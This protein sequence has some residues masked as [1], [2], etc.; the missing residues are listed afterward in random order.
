MRVLGVVT[1]CPVHAPGALPLKWDTLPTTIL[2]PTW[3]GG[4]IFKRRPSPSFASNGAGLRGGGRPFLNLCRILLPPPPRRFRVEGGRREKLEI[5]IPCQIKWS[6]WLQG[7]GRERRSKRLRKGRKRNGMT[8]AVA[9]PFDAG[10]GRPFIR[11]D[12]FSRWC[13]MTF[14]E[15]KGLSLVVHFGILGGLLEMFVSLA[16]RCM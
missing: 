9:H 3:R 16:H 11:H 6:G 13:S 2:F 7:R 10:G 1:E 15:G 5:E 14:Q 4:G 8:A 12:L